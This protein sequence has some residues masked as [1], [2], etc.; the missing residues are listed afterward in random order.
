VAKPIVDGIEKELGNRVPV[1]RLNVFSSI[2]RQAAA[3]FG[4]RGMPTLLVIDGDGNVILTQ[5][6]IIRPGIVHEQINTL[7]SQ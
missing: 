4:V 2:G 6:G 3:Y 7:L 1:I 5:P